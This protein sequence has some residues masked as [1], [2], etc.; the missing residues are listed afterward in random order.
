[1]G[2]VSQTSPTGFM[3]WAEAHIHD[4]PQCPGRSQRLEKIPR[5]AFR[6]AEAQRRQTKDQGRPR[7]GHEQSIRDTAKRLNVRPA[8]TPSSRPRTKDQGQRRSRARTKD[9][10]AAAMDSAEGATNLVLD[11]RQH[12][13]H[14]LPM[15]VIESVM[16]L[17]RRDK[18]QLMESLW[19]DLTQAEGEIDSPKWHEAV[20]HETERRLAAGEE[21]SIDWEEAKRCLRASR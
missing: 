3:G 11:L 9:S 13:H 4:R 5:S 1:M 7:S 2:R 16:R 20:L 21:E 12:S 6:M 8:P 18:L 14:A 15:N 19:V 10:R 17:P